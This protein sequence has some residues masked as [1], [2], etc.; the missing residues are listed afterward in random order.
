MVIL[1]SLP[2]TNDITSPPYAPVPVMVVW[3]RA[4]R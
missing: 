1:V 4:A 2:C 3:N